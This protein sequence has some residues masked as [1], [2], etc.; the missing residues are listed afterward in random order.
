MPT[1]LMLKAL[2]LNEFIWKYGPYFKF[3]MKWDSSQEKFLV[4]Q[5][6]FS[7]LPWYLFGLLPQLLFFIDMSYHL[8]SGL[9]H[10]HA[11]YILN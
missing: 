11:D 1:P 7:I 6:H 5:N 10:P 2:E 9:Y 3:Y 8:T 4:A